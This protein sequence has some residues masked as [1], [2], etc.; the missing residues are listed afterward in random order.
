MNWTKLII[1]G[2]LAAGGFLLH[3]TIF[4]DEK[5]K[6]GKSSREEKQR[7]IVN[8][9]PPE[10]S[11]GFFGRPHE[12]QVDELI[13]RVKEGETYELI[14]EAEEQNCK[15]YMLQLLVELLEIHDSRMLAETADTLTTFTPDGETSS[16]KVNAR[17]DDT[18]FKESLLYVIRDNVEADHPLVERIIRAFDA[19]S[20]AYTRYR[21]VRAIGIIGGERAKAFLE[22]VVEDEGG[23][24]TFS[25]QVAR[26]YLKEE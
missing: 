10:K 19:E 25:A 11:E 23:M 4:G 5:K 6:K 13:V 14:K 9:L 1:A 15:D 21:I 16:E 24:N 3:K 20:N 26:K 8:Y 12:K 17:V 22:R 18:D 2:A 7:P